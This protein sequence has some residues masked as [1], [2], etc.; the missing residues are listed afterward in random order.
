MALATSIDQEWE[1]A[2]INLMT[3][4]AAKGLEFDVVFLTRMGRRT[5][6]TSK[7]SRGK[8]RFCIRGRKKAGLCWNYQS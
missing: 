1:G 6:P 4:H 7:I 8:R 2:K 3:M 5:F